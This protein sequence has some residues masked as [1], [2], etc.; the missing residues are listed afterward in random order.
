MLVLTRRPNEEVVFPATATTVRVLGVK[1]G[2]VRLG[3]EAPPDVPALR[4]ELPDRAAEWAPAGAT[5][6]PAAAP[7]PDPA[8][9]P[10]GFGL[11]DTAVGLGL[12][13]LQ[14]D[15]GL[16]EDARAT[17]AA[18]REGLRLL[19]AGAGP[20]P[21]PAPPPGK[22]P[23]ALLVEDDRNERELLAGFLRHC[24]LEVDTAGDGCDAL[25]YLRSGGRP[26]VVLLD[27]GLPRCDGPTTVR[28][29][30]GDPAYAG[31]KIFA[32]TGYL[33]DE[34]DLASG[35]AGIDRW[36]HK[37]VDPAG[38]ARDLSRELGGVT[39]GA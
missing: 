9:L 17:L 19:R 34:F 10:P 37:P 6:A 30:R 28:Q 5:A 3:I 1:K 4:G 16:I 12:A 11:A 20:A 14:L 33:P 38:L 2:A 36:F 24:G 8:R 26:D 7:S 32:V 39:C 35:P 25:D 23:R 18:M 21:S 27:M 31:L 29:I 13:Q 22:A 15:A